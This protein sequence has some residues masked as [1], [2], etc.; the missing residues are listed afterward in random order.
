MRSSVPAC[1]IPAT[2]VRPPFLTFVAVRA[3]APVAGMPPKIGDTMLATPWATSS[4]LERWRPPIMPSATTAD[5]KDSMAPSSAMVN[6]GAARVVSIASV[7]WGSAGR[8]RPASMT[9][10]RV[11]IVSTGRCSAR[12]STV[13]TI[14]ATNGPGM[15]RSTLGHTRIMTKVAKA[16]RSAHGLSDS[17]ACTYASHL[18]TNAAGTALISRPRRS[19]TWLEKMMSAMPLVNPMV[20]G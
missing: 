19:R 4:M 8:G 6:A 9:P 10:K 17:N 15:R 12:T 5:S 7:T 14:R 13:V 3:M 11:P 2:G 1:V 18:A 20:T 16:T